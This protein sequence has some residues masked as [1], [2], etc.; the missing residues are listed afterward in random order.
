MADVLY[1]KI[2]LYD[3]ICDKLQKRLTV[4]QTIGLMGYCRTILLGDEANGLLR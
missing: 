1:H 2:A 3:F 4:H